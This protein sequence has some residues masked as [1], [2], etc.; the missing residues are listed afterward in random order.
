MRTLPSLV[1]TLP[2]PHPLPS[3]SPLSP[4]RFAAMASSAQSASQRANLCCISNVRDAFDWS[5]SGGLCGM[6]C[7]LLS[8]Q[9]TPHDSW[10]CAMSNT[11][12]RCTAAVA[13]D[14]VGRRTQQETAAYRWRGAGWGRAV[15]STANQWTPPR[16]VE[17]CL[18]IRACVR[19]FRLHVPP[20]LP[21][22]ACPKASRILASC[23]DP[24]SRAGE[25]TQST[26]KGCAGTW[27]PAFSQ[28]SF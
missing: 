18:R 27:P 20:L 10:H 15:G 17:M 8:R 2:L 5:A 4:F 6:L 11:E 9:R 1:A 28:I 3:S 22:S 14:S 21:L 12:L 25:T 13:A 19:A 23:C 26:P 7:K 16:T 24:F